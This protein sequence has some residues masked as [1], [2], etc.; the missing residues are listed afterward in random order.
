MIE[1]LYESILKYHP[2]YFD[3]QLKEDSTEEAKKTKVLLDS[4]K[5]LMHGSTSN[6]SYEV[7]ASDL[8][9]SKLLAK[10]VDYPYPLPPTKTY[11]L[12]DS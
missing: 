2:L 6:Q 10:L 1:S 8:L 3:I 12:P 7:R 9:V 4:L 11:Q 5:R